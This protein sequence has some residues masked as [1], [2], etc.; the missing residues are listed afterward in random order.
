MMAWGS[1]KKT[2]Y[3]TNYAGGERK[4]QKSCV[5]C[6]PDVCRVSVVEDV[7]D[8]EE[9]ALAEEREAL[10]LQKRMIATLDEN[11]FDL[12]RFQV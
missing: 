12:H 2:F 5:D 11:D 3:D 7:S 1:D 9:A 6:E 4:G 10:A 8:V